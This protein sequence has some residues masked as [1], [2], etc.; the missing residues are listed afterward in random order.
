M[1]AAKLLIEQF[2]GF[3][4][5]LILDEGMVSWGVLETWMKLDLTLLG[6]DQNLSIFSLAGTY[7]VYP[8]GSGNDW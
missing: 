4:D 5:F 6:D 3:L 2:A 1:Y 8:A 7:A